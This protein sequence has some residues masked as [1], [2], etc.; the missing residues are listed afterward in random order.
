MLFDGPTPIS[1]C[2]RTRRGCAVDARLREDILDYNQY[3]GAHRGQV[4]AHVKATKIVHQAATVGGLCGATCSAVST[5]RR[6]R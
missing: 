4:A 3:E 1:T 2:L 5:H 6:E